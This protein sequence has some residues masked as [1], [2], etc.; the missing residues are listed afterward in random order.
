MSRT[1]R[2]QTEEAQ[3]DAS[4]EA[5]N[6]PETDP[7]PKAKRHRR[8]AEELAAAGIA[9]KAKADPVAAL[10]AARESLL[11]EQAALTARLA[12]VNEALGAPENSAS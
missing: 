3:A 12:I 5:A 11:A 1:S 2:R 7:P 10:K 8:T 4:D 9:R 6:A